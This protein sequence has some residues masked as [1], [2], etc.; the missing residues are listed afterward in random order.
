MLGGNSVEA[1]GRQCSS[2][3]LED[4]CGQLGILIHNHYI[5]P[6]FFY[7]VLNDRKNCLSLHM[8]DGS[9]LSGGQSNWSNASSFSVEEYGKRAELENSIIAQYVAHRDVCTFVEWFTQ[10]IWKKRFWKSL[11]WIKLTFFYITAI[12]HSLIGQGVSMSSATGSCSF[13]S[14]NGS[15]SSP[16]ATCSQSVERLLSCTWSVAADELGSWD[17][18]KQACKV[19]EG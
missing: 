19:K 4:R 12:I 5:F 6:F 3:F 18:N 10:I 2:L 11:G 17:L 8:L 16:S 9:L 1:G 14:A 15:L 7:S 13:L